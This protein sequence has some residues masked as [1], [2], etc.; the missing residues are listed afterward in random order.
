MQALGSL[1]CASPS[2]EAAYQEMIHGHPQKDVPQWSDSMPAPLVVD[3]QLVLAALKGFPRG[4]S[5]ESSKLRAQ[6]IVDAVVGQLLRLVPLAW[7]S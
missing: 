3:T 5:P 7:R 4:S 2:D 6:H 1:G